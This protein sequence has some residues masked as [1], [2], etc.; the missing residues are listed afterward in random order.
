MT[1]SQTTQRNMRALARA[2][3]QA[4]SELR[5]V[6]R[7]ASMFKKMALEEGKKRARQQEYDANILRKSLKNFA[8][9]FYQQ[10]KELDE[11]KKLVR[12]YR[13]ENAT[14]LE[15]IKKKKTRRI[16]NGWVVLG[17]TDI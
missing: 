5:Q 4:Q 14:L 6:K 17:K 1:K 13:M 16:Q 9:P 2:L 15:N 10:K 8:G 12:K 7:N 11:M 3:R